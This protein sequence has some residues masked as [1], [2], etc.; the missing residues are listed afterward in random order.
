MGDRYRSHG[1]AP[2]PHVIL[3][4]CFFA[5]DLSWRDV[6]WKQAPPEERSVLARRTMIGG[7]T[8]H[9]P[10]YPTN[11]DK[12]K[13]TRSYD[14]NNVK[15]KCRVRGLGYEYVSVTLLVLANGEGAWD[16]PLLYYAFVPTMSVDVQ[17]GCWAITAA[18]LRAPLDQPESVDEGPLYLTVLLDAVN[19]RKCLQEYT[20]TFDQPAGTSKKAMSCAQ[21]ARP[22]HSIDATHVQ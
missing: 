16:Q 4:F 6:A 10:V 11:T 13:W 7:R 9:S 17:S 18:F 14:V 3:W 5:P 1:Q 2:R 22:D 21:M 8:A 19:S 15:A 20:A 12:C